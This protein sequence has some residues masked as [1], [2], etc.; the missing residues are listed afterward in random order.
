MFAEPVL[1]VFVDDRELRGNPQEKESRSDDGGE[2]ERNYYH[3][4]VA[5]SCR[6][7]HQDES[8]CPQYRQKHNH[9]NYW[10]WQCVEL[11]LADPLV[12]MGDPAAECH[13][14]F[15]CVG[16]VLIEGLPIFAISLNGFVRLVLNPLPLLGVLADDLGPESLFYTGNSLAELPDRG[17]T[18]E[19]VVAEESSL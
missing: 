10:L 4:G 12:G 17:C 2:N 3:F 7:E 19:D 1:V 5:L 16:D 11:E 15:L 9:G 13:T 14:V 18:G 8:S 6:G